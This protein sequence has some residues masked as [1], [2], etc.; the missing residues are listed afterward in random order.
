VVAGAAAAAA[1]AAAVAVG[2]VVIAVLVVVV[3]G[4]V[5][6]EGLVTV[7]VVALQETIRLMAEI[8][9]VIPSWPNVCFRQCDAYLRALT[10]RR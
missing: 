1:A 7:V 5:V 8:G 9:Q 4:V 3:V 6:V 10:R 2:R